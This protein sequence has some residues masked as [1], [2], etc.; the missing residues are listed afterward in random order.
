MV[1][2]SGAA[3]CELG[4][5]VDY[6]LGGATPYT[7]FRSDDGGTDWSYDPIP[8][9]VGGISDFG[10]SSASVC[11]AAGNGIAST[12][13]GG[14]TWSA[15]VSQSS[16]NAEGVTTVA[17]ISCV[18]GGRC[19]AVG[20]GGT[21]AYILD[22][23]TGQ[24]STSRLPVCAGARLPEIGDPCRPAFADVGAL[25]RPLVLVWQRSLCPGGPPV[26]VASAGV[27]PFGIGETR[28]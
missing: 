10:C 14:S 27:D 7:I 11:F 23:V 16:M 1:R 5:A 21:G 18:P 9:T 25:G 8:T 13:D 4:Y 19:W 12:A 15:S 28:G 3:T 24:Q 6:G 2:C 22:T 20:S 26:V 17:D